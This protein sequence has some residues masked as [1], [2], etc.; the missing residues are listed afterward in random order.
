A[1]VLGIGIKTFK[2][3]R[4]EATAFNYA[5][6]DSEFAARSQLLPGV[7]S[8]QQAQ[9]AQHNGETGSLEIGTPKASAQLPKAININAAS[10]DELMT[11]PGIGEAMAERIVLYREENGP[12]ASV[13]ELKNIKGIGEKK[14]ERIAPL[15]TLGK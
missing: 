12:F 9:R 14:L 5:A 7:D 11:L 3:N 15:C 4:Q 1:F 6:S 13:D 2:S 8:S 10:K